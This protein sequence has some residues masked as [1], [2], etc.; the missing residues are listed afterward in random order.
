MNSIIFITLALSVYDKTYQNDQ[1]WIQYKEQFGK[2]YSD[3]SDEVKRYATFTENDKKIKDHNEK[4]ML[5]EVTYEMGHNQFSDMSEEELAEMYSSPRLFFEDNFPQDFD[6]NIS[7]IEVPSSW[8][9]KKYC[10]P[11]LSQGANCGDCWS[12]ASTAQIE[13]QRSLKHGIKS[14]LSTQYILDCS[15]AGNCE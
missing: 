3:T 5:G 1:K 6:L 7:S 15:G 2:I 14:Y 13:A 4:Y 9:Y 10:L 11:P 8:S 12:F